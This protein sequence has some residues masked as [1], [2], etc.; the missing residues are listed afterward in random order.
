MTDD[1]AE[2]VEQLE[3][4]VEGLKGVHDQYKEQF[5]KPRINELQQARDD[6][7]E[8]RAELAED[9]QALRERV[10]DLEV[11]I[12]SVIGLAEDESGGPDKRCADLRLGLIRVVESRADSTTAGKHWK[13]V[14]AFFAEQGHGDVSKPLCYRA[15]DAAAEYQGFSLKEDAM[16]LP[17]GRTGRAIVVDTDRLPDSGVVTASNDV[18]TRESG[19]KGES[20]MNTM[21]E[22][23]ESD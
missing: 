5:V 13:G 9:V 17:S 22:A 16:T 11:G 18:T 12:D 6:A 23:A 19:E 2:R 3:E 15:M 7:R 14:Q 10:R 8:E 21:A 20:P 4:K 1:L